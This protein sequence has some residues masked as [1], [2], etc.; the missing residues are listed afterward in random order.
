VD[1][2]P[3]RS[4]GW[5]ENP[6]VKRLDNLHDQSDYRL[7]REELAAQPAFLRGKMGQE[8]L[9]DKPEGVARKLPGLW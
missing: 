2:H 9:V 1:K 5:V 6:A 8:V 7:G 4:A 3:A